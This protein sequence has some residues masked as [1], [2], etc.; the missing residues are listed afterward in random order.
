M[1][2]PFPIRN[3]F[4]SYTIIGPHLSCVIQTHY[5]PQK[6]RN[7][8]LAA[9]QVPSSTVAIPATKKIRWRTANSM[10]YLLLSQTNSSVSSNSLDITSACSRQ[11]HKIWFFWS[12]SRSPN[13]PTLT[14]SILQSPQRLSSRVA[15]GEKF[16]SVSH[17]SVLTSRWQNFRHLILR[18][19]RPNS[20]LSVLYRRRWSHRLLRNL[21]WD[22]F[23]TISQFSR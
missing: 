12:P 7:T 19:W 5:G 10:L 17:T 22:T 8:D 16:V 6:P 11:I 18:Q 4:G 9:A 20:L 14:W 1:S 23:D 15:R 3:S 13:P 21:L 2:L